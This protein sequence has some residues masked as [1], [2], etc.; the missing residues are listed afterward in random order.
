MHHST[1]LLCAAGEPENE[2]DHRDGA[3]IKTASAGFSKSTEGTRLLQH[4][5]VSLIDCKNS[6]ILRRCL[7]LVLTSVLRN[8]FTSEYC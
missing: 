2:G 1:S 8:P 7:D 3:Q 6:L 4:E 5:C